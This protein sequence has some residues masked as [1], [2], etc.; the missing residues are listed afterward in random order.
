MAAEGAELGVGLG[1][2]PLEQPAITVARLRSRAIRPRIDIDESYVAFR[3]GCAH[4][5]LVPV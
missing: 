5:K 4:E 2:A 1:A 3:G